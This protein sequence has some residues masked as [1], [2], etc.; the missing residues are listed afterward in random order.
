MSGYSNGISAGALR[1][2]NYLP[3][4][5]KM[6]EY[7]QNAEIPETL[8]STMQ[9]IVVALKNN[10]ILCAANMHLSQ[11]MLE[12]LQG[13]HELANS[14]L[15]YMKGNL[16]AVGS[17]A[18]ML[19]VADRNFLQPASQDDGKNT[20]TDYFRIALKTAG[21]VALGYSVLGTLSN[22]GNVKIQGQVLDDALLTAV[23]QSKQ[24]MALIK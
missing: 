7:L 1:L 19:F 23:G 15:D 8:K 16:L 14:Q 18:V 17:G 11:R 13:Y 5:H 12:V 6:V 20:R 24:I 10:T 21:Y 22:L 9:A 4:I 3:S 2:L